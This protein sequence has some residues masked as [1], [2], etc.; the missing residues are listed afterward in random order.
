MNSKIAAII[1]TAG[2]SSRMGQPKALM[3]WGRSCLLEHLVDEVHTADIQ[4]L[5]LVTGAHHQE[6]LTALPG[7]KHLICYNAE[8]ESGMGRSI[9]I[10]A[11]YLTT[12]FPELQGILILLIDQPLIHASYLKEMITHFESDSCKIVAS[13]F[14]DTKGA[15]A[16]FGKAYFKN[17][18]QL[19][20]DQGAKPIIEQA[21]TDVFLLQA[22]E[23]AKD[24]DTPDAYNQLKE[25]YGKI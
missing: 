20:K 22:D 8:W 12:R 9:G 23:L 4:N 7:F 17:L 1:L 6:I 25:K 5:I 14:K 2:S 10:G 16:L 11:T 3:S 21:G 15:P 19:S 24:V 18:Q 13:Q